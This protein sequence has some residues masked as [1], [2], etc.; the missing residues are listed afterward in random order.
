MMS[1]PGGGMMSPRWWN[2]ENWWWI[3]HLA[4]KVTHVPV[5]EDKKLFLTKKLREK[6][7]PYRG[8]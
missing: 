2:E 7:S 1:P 5:F 4:K 3:Y 6:N 8:A